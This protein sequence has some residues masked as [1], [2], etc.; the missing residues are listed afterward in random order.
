METT[1]MAPVACGFL[2]LKEYWNSQ[3]MVLDG[4]ETPP[5]RYTHHHRHPAQ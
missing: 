4:I 2:M 3:K 5:Y 1:R